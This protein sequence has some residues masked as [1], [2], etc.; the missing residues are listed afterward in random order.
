MVACV[1]VVVQAE[2]EAV[3]T[4]DASAQHGQYGYTVAPTPYGPE[5]VY[6]V[7]TTRLASITVSFLDSIN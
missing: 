4:A 1:A 2:A 7:C 5:P 6:Q 3:A